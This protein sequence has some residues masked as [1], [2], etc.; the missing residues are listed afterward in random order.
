MQAYAYEVRFV[1][2][3]NYRLRHRAASL[4]PGFVV[5]VEGLPPAHLR[6]RGPSCLVGC[7]PRDAG[8]GGGP[9]KNRRGSGPAFHRREPLGRGHPPCA[10]CTCAATARAAGD[11][12]SLPDRLPAAHIEPS[13]LRRLAHRRGARAGRQSGAG[14]LA[15]PP[16]RG[17]PESGIAA[18]NRWLMDELQSRVV[19]TPNGDRAVWSARI[20]LGDW[21]QNLTLMRPSP[22]SVTIGR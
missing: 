13:D 16:A 1:R 6:A 15:G 3:R 8:V 14:C 9:G 10:H 18:D 17:R 7:D 21:Q 22:G 4:L 20:T 2:N 19:L 11:G 5:P 12:A